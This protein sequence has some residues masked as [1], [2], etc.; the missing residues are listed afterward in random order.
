MRS[1]N[2]IREILKGHQ[3]IPVVSFKKGDDPFH[4]M[5]YLIQSGVGCMEVTLRSDFSMEAIEIL[6]KNKPENFLVGAGTVINKEQITELKKLKIDFL[7]SPSFTNDLLESMDNSGIAYLPGV[8]TP[9]DIMEAI[10]NGLGNLKFF[11]ASLFGGIEALE[12]YGKVFPQVEFCPTGGID[13][14]SS[15]NYLKLSNVFAVGGSWF[16]KTYQIIK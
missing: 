4:F 3:E 1:Q 7:V 13:K 5:E 10:E 6:Q 11:P 12:A 16:Q 9:K 14:M 2:N 15:R 8:A